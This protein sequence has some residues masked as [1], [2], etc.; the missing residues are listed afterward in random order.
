MQPSEFL[1]IGFTIYMATWLSGMKSQIADVKNGTLPFILLLGGV[2]IPLLLQPDTDTYLIMV[3]ASL[4]MF[5]T[6]GGKIRDV[7]IMGIAGVLLL[8]VLAFMRPYIKDRIETFL[9]PAL[10][11]S[12]M[13]IVMIASFLKPN[14]LFLK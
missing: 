8:A 13:G 14:S 3:A 10:S 4:A 11:L 5:I 1:K 2:G 6:A 9:N 7:I 12:G